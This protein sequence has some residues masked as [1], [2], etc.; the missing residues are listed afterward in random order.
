MS[1]RGT[2]SPHSRPHSPALAALTFHGSFPTKVAATGNA[3]A[4]APTSDQA[5]PGGLSIYAEP[6]G[7]EPDAASA[8]LQTRR[9]IRRAFFADGGIE[10]CHRAVGAGRELQ[11]PWTGCGDREGTQ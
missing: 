5:A 8:A 1:S 2:C 9:R 6:V 10:K 7:R 4:R 3:P 11:S